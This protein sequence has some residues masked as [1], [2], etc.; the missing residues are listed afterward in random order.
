MESCVPSLVFRTWWLVGL[1][2]GRSRCCHWDVAGFADA[3][4]CAA[5]SPVR[6]AQRGQGAGGVAGSRGLLPP[7]GPGRDHRPGLPGSRGGAGHPRPGH[8][9]AG[10]QPA[11]LATP[12]VPTSKTGQASGRCGRSGGSTRRCSTMIASA[13]RW[14]RSRPGWSRSWGRS[15]PARSPPSGWT[16]PACTG[17]YLDLAVRRL[18]RPRRRLPYPPLRP[19]QGPVGA[20]YSVTSRDLRIL[21]EQPTKPIPPHHPPSRHEHQWFARSQRRRLPQGA[22]RPMG[23]V[24]VGILTQHR[25]QTPTPDDQ[26]LVEALAAE[27]ADLA[28]HPHPWPAPSTASDWQGAPGRVRVTHPFHP[29]SGREFDLAFRR[30]RG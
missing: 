16:W 21:M 14:T 20:R 6:C 28:L 30:G 23:V 8:R 15:V 25:H 3:I 24:V 26:Q 18:S 17:I 12:L 22:M 2:W 27:P 13:G 29:L 11:D 10:R 4:P 19:S 9:G 1:W 5:S 7:A